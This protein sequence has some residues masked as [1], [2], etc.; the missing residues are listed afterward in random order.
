MTCA[1]DFCHPLSRDQ[2]RSFRPRGGTHHGTARSLVD[3]PIWLRHGG[4]A[5]GNDELMSEQQRDLFDRQPPPWEVDDQR[6]LCV[7]EIVFAESPFGPYD[8]EVPA[9]LRERVQ[10][11]VRVE[12]PLGRGNR[13]RLGYCVDVANAK[14][15]SRSLKTISAIVDSETLLS[16]SMLRLT[17]WMSTYYLCPL[18]QVLDAVVPSGVRGQAG[19]REQIFLRVPTAI[20]AR[21]TQLKLPPKQAAALR[22]LALSPTPLTP[23]DLRGPLSALR[24]PLPLCDTRSWWWRK[25][26]E[27]IRGSWTRLSASVRN[28]CR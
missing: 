4:L 7:A 3:W 24:R 26:G 12:V 21:F 27:C 16:P 17:R 5:A 18:G 14:E 8:Y 19:T 28:T 2:A 1:L 15:T 13:K 23:A 10:P 6:E 20:A 25:C 9:A 11:G 22:I